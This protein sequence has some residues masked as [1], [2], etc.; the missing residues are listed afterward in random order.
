M[1]DA[2]RIASNIAK[3]PALLGAT[4][5]SE[6]DLSRR[7][8]LI[9]VGFSRRSF[10]LGASVAGERH[11]DLRQS[12]YDCVAPVLGVSRLQTQPRP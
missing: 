12:L 5:E 2:R 4:E 10:I 7:R 3:L 9:G 8:R 11:P 6:L 1:D